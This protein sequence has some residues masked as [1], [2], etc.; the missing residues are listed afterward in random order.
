MGNVI[1]T[2]GMK[3]L[4]SDFFKKSHRLVFSQLA[5]SPVEHDIFA[6]FLTK[7]N[8]EQWQSFLNKETIDSPQYNFSSDV[9]C[10]WFGIEKK[11]LYSTLRDPARR[12][13]GKS[14]G[15]MDDVKRRFKFQ[16]LFKEV[17]YEDGELT[18]VPNDLLI[19]EYLSI[20]QGHSQVP[21]RI[22]R[23]IEKEHA[24]RLYTI[25][26]RFKGGNNV[27]HPQSIDDL[28]A[29]FGLLDDKG[30]LLKRTYA[31]TG[32][33]INRII[34]PAIQEI[35][36]KESLINFQVDEKTGNYGFSYLKKGRKIV[37][38]RFLFSWLE[39]T[40]KA[41]EECRKKLELELSTFDKAVLV[42]DL[43]QQYQEGECGNPTVEELNNLVA[44]ASLLMENGKLLDAEFM[45]KFAGAMNEAKLL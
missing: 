8:K 15:V 30:K 34:K 9:L 39:K 38:I 45:M 36:E 22:F 11:Y 25:L 35:D 4:H 37:A 14:I 6:L 41:E 20:S 13:S 26:C 18:I 21:H 17:R 42:Y 24:K 32:N 28:H 19:S 27:L 33:L 7:L 43:V 40:N 12:L 1:A 10:E 23:Q 16:T 29:F 44:N 5:L 31:V 3:D 2:A